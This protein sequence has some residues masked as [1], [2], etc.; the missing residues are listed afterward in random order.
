MENC[1][2]CGGRKRF[3]KIVR[4]AV[5]PFR[6]VKGEHIFL[7]RVLVGPGADSGLGMASLSKS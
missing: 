1:F 6:L 2:P 7:Y 5:L 4:N 3:E